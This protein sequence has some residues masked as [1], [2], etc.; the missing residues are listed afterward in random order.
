[1]ASAGRRSLWGWSVPVRR[2]LAVAVLIP[3]GWLAWPVRHDASRRVD[4]S[5]VVDVN[6][7]PPGVL[8]ALPRLGPVL[9]G[10]IVKG[11]QER[12]F[13]SLGELD[14][15]VR[16]IGPVTAAA[17]RPYLRFPGP[18]AEEPGAAPSLALREPR[19]EP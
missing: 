3:A 12:P 10:R 15:R 18:P 4:P 19:R 9:V 11:R 2:L 16:G 1:M 5:L 7:A 6:T 17:L 14:T 13:R 8:L